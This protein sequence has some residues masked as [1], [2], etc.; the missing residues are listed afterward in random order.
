[1]FFFLQDFVGP[2]LPPGWVWTSGWSIDKG[3]NVDDDG[4]FYGPDFQSLKYPP[5]SIKGKRK[6]TFDFARRRR[7][8]RARQCVPETQH[9]H[10]RQV[11]GLVEPGNSIPL[12]WAGSDPKANICVQVRPQSD[13]SP[14]SWGTAISDLIAQSKTQDGSD[15]APSFSTRQSKNNVPVSAL[16]LKDLEKTEEVLLCRG[17][18]GGGSRGI[19]WLNV[20]VDATVLYS[21]VNVPIPDWRI[22]V[23]AP[24]KLENRLPCTAAYIVWEKPR[25]S[26]NLVKQQDGIVLA[27][28]SVYI[29][30]V[31]VRRPI[32]LTWLAQGGWR[33]EKEVVVISDP[34]MEDLPSGFWMAHQASGRYV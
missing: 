28:G 9:M 29:H 17:S 30:A 26:G 33:P 13:S 6:S 5:S 14:Y 3:G 23:N 1:M 20:E 10:T 11:V 4:W 34:G 16:L 18:G 27:G 22:T 32:Y 2:P 8:L 12:P 24:V 7:L 21:E 15:G 31:D 19:C 25:S